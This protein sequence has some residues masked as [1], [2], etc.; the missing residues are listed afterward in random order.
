MKKSLKQVFKYK[1]CIGLL[2]K[3]TKSGMFAYQPTNDIGAFYDIMSLPS[4][5]VTKIDII[6]K[7]EIIDN[8]YIY[9]FEEEDTSWYEEF[10]TMEQAI[11]AIIAREEER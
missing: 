5:Y 8:Y 7:I 10:E 11:K 6:T 2:V 4:E 9:Y 1:N 3:H